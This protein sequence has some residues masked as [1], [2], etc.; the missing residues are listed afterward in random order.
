M[1]LRARDITKKFVTQSGEVR[2][3]ESFTLDVNRGEF[4]TIFGPN[5]CGKSTLVNIIAGLLQPDAGTLTSERGTVE[6][7]RKCYV[8]QNYRDALLPWRSVAENIAFPLK[9][10]GVGRGPRRQQVLSLMQ[11]FGITLDPDARVY[12]LSGGEQQI[13]SI[14]RG[15][16]IEPEIMLL[17]EPFSALDYQMNLVMEA[18]IMEIWA[19]TKITT[20]FVSHDLDQ[21]ILLADRIVLLSRGPGRIREVFTNTLPRPR[22]VEMLGDPSHVALKRRILSLFQGDTL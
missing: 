10:A 21:A 14:M 4:I 17:D 8:W 16:I 7:I 18:K 12:S 11:R 3:I 2:G 5:G 19:K 1:M 22:T 15:L 6:Q 13:V 20:V 9:L